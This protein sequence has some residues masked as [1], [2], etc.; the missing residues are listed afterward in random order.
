MQKRLPVW[1]LQPLLPPAAAGYGDIDIAH[2][3]RLPVASEKAYGVN[4]VFWQE[5]YSILQKRYRTLQ[6]SRL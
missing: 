5:Q 6:E 1:R 2:Y 3:L 4:A